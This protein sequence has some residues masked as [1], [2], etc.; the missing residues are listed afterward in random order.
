MHCEVGPRNFWQLGRGSRSSTFGVLDV[1]HD[2]ISEAVYLGTLR[3][4]RPLLLWSSR[5]LEALLVEL[6][7]ISRRTVE[8]RGVVEETQG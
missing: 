1:R 5:I 2:G 7:G 4:H 8:V 3:R 6:E